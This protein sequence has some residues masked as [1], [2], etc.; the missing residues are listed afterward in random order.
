MFLK[1]HKVHFS[2]FVLCKPCHK[3]RQ[4]NFSVQVVLF[5]ISSSDLER[6]TILILSFQMKV[7]DWEAR[8]IF[9]LR[10]L[11]RLFLFLDEFGQNILE[12][13]PWEKAKLNYSIMCLHTTYNRGEMDKVM[14]ENTYYVTSLR[15]PVDVFESQYSYYKLWKHYGMNLGNIF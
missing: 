7:E 14:E 12:D 10:T 4:C 13:T 1:M 3:I 9:F 6:R 2:K 5:K 11:S 8:G 15:N